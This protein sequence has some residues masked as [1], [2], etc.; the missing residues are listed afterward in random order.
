MSKIGDQVGGIASLPKSLARLL[1]LENRVNES[2]LR[3]ANKVIG[4]YVS[5][6][7]PR[8]RQE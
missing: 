6:G 7:V 1:F 5:E 3:Q 4:E 2:E 8:A